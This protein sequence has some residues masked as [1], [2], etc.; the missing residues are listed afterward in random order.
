M[1]SDPVYCT[2]SFTDAQN[3][4][5]NKISKLE[6]SIN[7]HSEQ[8]KVTDNLYKEALKYDLPEDMKKERLEAKKETEVNLNSERRALRTLKTRFRKF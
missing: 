6:D 5:L 2:D 4:L 3:E 1:F 8:A 7:Y